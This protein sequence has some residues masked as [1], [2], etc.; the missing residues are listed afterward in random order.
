MT[1]RLFLIT[2]LFS[3]VGAQEWF[4]WEG[5]VCRTISVDMKCTFL[6][7]LVDGVEFVSDTKKSWFVP[8]AL[9]TIGGEREYQA[10]KLATASLVL[11]GVTVIGLKYTVNR[12]RPSGEYSR[13]DSSFPSGH[14]A[15]AVTTSIVYSKFYPKL[16]IPLILYSSMVGFARVYAQEHYPTDVL[17]GAILGAGISYVVL[18]FKDEIISFP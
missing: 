4:A 2:F 6:N 16:T 18:N 11:S 8:L 14:T 3:A 17:A 7:N 1:K 9:Y 12:Q 10:A 13:W 15:T 5:D